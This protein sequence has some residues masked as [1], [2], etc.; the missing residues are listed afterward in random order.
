MKL[1]VVGL[2]YV[3]NAVYRGLRRHFDVKWYDKAK[4]PFGL[5]STPDDQMV[6]VLDD[7]VERMADLMSTDIIFVCVPT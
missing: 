3:G 7:R 2:G 6:R 5:M 1:G 4:Y